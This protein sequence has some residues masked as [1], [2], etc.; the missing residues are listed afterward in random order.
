[1]NLKLYPYVRIKKNY[2]CLKQ[3]PAVLAGLRYFK[4]AESPIRSLGTRTLIKFILQQMHLFHVDSRLVIDL[5]FFGQYCLPVHRGFKVFNLCKRSVVK[6]F[7]LETDMALVKSEIERVR[8]AARLAP[9]PSVRLWN[10]EDRWYEE[11][12]IEGTSERSFITSNPESLLRRYK[13]YIIPLVEEIIL[14][15][16]PIIHELSEHINHIVR[17]MEQKKFSEFD[18]SKVREIKIFVNFIVKK[19]RANGARQIYFAFTHGDFH[20]ENIS[21]TKKGLK[22]IDWELAQDRSLLHD[23]YNYFFHLVRNKRLMVNQ[24]SLINEALSILCSRMNLKS[25]HLT[26][27]ILS[28]AHVYRWIYYLERIAVILHFRDRVPPENT[29]R[30]ILHNIQVFKGFEHSEI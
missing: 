2:F 11:E 6:V 25:P 22:V 7:S 15:Q 4:N 14:F 29:R 28:N 12:Y 19:L 18:I 26:R 27:H 8:K 1:M 17:I 9:S 23:F 16:T 5:P 30:N 13:E 10:I 24:W 20:T 21:N 3:N